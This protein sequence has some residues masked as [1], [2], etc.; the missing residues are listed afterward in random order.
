[1]SMLSGRSSIHRKSSSPKAMRIRHGRHI[2]VLAFSVGGRTR[3]ACPRDHGVKFGNSHRYLRARCM[4][5]A[6]HSVSADLP[7]TSMCPWHH[8]SAWATWL[9]TKDAS[10]TRYES[11]LI[12]LFRVC[13]VEG[14][15]RVPC[16][17]PALINSVFDTCACTV[18]MS[19]QHGPHGH[20]PNLPLGLGTSRGRL[21]FSGVRVVEVMLAGPMRA[22][23]TDSLRVRHMC[24]YCMHA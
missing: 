6:P 3:P 10:G 15:W 21:P 12:A 13:V 18:Y 14:C 11:W 22:A 17:Q 16:E 8:S 9:P 24:V 23:R 5:R 2:C 1:M 20:P 4:A 19:E 7:H